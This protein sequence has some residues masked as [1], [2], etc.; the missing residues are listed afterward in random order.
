MQ[1]FA[2]AYDVISV[3]KTSDVLKKGDYK[4]QWSSEGNGTYNQSVQN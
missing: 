1:I 2:Y 3:G 4:P